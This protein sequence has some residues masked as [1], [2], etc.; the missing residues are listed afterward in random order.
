VIATRRILLASTARGVEFE[1]TEGERAV[2]YPS[3]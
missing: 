2:K 1:L 3:Q